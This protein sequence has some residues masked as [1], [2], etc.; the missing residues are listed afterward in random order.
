MAPKCQV[1]RNRYVLRFHENRYAKNAEPVPSNRF[2]N[3][4]LAVQ[5]EPVRIGSTHCTV[6][7]QWLPVL[8]IVGRRSG[9]VRRRALSSA[10]PF[11]ASWPAAALLCCAGHVKVGHHCSQFSLC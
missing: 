9:E 7:S 1:Q 10:S 8:G 2:V 6:P 5:A 3:R 11:I 4:F